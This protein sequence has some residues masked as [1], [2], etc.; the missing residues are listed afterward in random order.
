[1]RRFAPFDYQS[2]SG[3]PE[4]LIIGGL[5]MIQS[6]SK[7]KD[8]LFDCLNSMSENPWIYTAQDN[9]FS[10][11]R[12]ISFSDTV[13]STICMQRSSS[14]TEILKYYDFQPNAPTHSALIQQRK[15]LL[16]CAFE[17]LFYRFTNAL[18]P[19]LRY[20]GYRLFA[21]DGSDIYIPRNPNDPDTY[22]VSDIYGKGFNMLH[23]NAAYDLAAKLYTDIIIQ[24][25]NHINEYSAMCDMIDRYAQLHPN[26]KAIFIADRGYVSFNV[27]AHAI[28]NGT[29][30]LI[31][32]REPSCRSMLS[33]LEL[34]DEPEFDITFERWLTRR[35]TNTVKTQPEI[36][37]SIASRVFDYL[38]PKSKKIYYISFR[39]IKLLLPNGSEEY[40]YTNLPKEEFTLDEIRK[41]YNRRWGIETSFRDI[42]YAAGMLFFHSRKK[43]LVLQ[44]IY[45]KLILYNFSEAVTGGI[46]LQKGKH[47]FLYSINFATA[48][49]L[50]VE[51]IRRSSCRRTPIELDKLIL[52]HLVAIRPGRS[53]PRYIR[54][55]T[56]TSFLYR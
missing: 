1:M 31:R 40:I 48:I 15:K 22:R 16:P 2:N 19:D 21:V 45:A 50:C 13:L 6:S 20:K 11:K 3:V 41:L 49:S 42:K 38:E 56:A 55:R 29:F 34:P 30:F 47:G 37:K 53:S 25:V 5:F 7:V 54:A 23:L 28:E 9:Q 26:D 10:R 14:K 51:F 24:P 43:Q 4:N 17:D 36:Y 35:N 44:E 39:I 18:S 12:K 46:V 33:K 52:R 8:I 27:F 32:A